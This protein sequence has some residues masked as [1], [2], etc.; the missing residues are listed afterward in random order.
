MTKQEILNQINEL[1]LQLSSLRTTL[2]TMPDKVE[3]TPKK[4]DPTNPEDIFN[5][6]WNDIEENFDFEK[7]QKM[8][9]A[10][11]WRWFWKDGELT[12]EDIKEGVKKEI[13]YTLERKCSC[14][15]GGFEYIYRS[16]QD[17]AECFGCEPSKGIWPTVDVKFVGEEW[18]TDF[19]YDESNNGE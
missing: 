6:V 8:M 2:Y 19:G 5:H 17:A 10:V 13:G 3:E 1:Q 16:P 11:G 18:E 15:T 14:A 7:V 9:A 12:V 4:P